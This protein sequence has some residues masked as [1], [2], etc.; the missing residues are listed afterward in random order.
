MRWWIICDDINTGE[1]F[2]DGIIE[3]CVDGHGPGPG[4]LGFTREAVDL[5]LSRL[6]AK[7][8][9]ETLTA[10]YQGMSWPLSLE[11]KDF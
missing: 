11:M 4:D 7:S 6:R 10:D 9:G 1:T 8:N 5:E 2:D 3:P